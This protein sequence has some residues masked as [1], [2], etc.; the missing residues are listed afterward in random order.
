M[1]SF[2]VCVA[3]VFTCSAVAG[4]QTMQ[5]FEKSLSGEEI[6]KRVDK[7]RIYEKI[8][9]NGKMTIRKGNK[10]I[11][12]TMHVFAEGTA[13]S[14]IEFTNTEDKG[15]K[16]LKLSDELWMYFPDAEE[17]VKISG[18]MLRESM[19]GSDFSYEDVMENEEL[20]KRYSI[21]VPGSEIINGSDCY[22]LELS[23]KDKKITYAKR[24]LWVD[25]ERFVVLKAQL[26]AL[27]GKLLKESAMENVKKYGNRYFIT[28]LTM[29]NNL[30]KN[31]A[32]IF[33]LADIKFDVNI[34]EG[35]F[36]RRSLGKL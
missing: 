23:A 21:N 31:S 20:I 11:I 13:R 33:E 8:E 32:T 6:M 5:A 22:V 19:M 9:Y 25:K 16:Y 12:K 27:S 14:F 29:M 4:S 17:E 2:A 15:T 28:K 24:K 18:H 3:L 10:S 36:S 30:T 7:N 26:F 1:T 35:V 34:P